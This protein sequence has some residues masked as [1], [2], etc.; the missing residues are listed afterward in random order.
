M[1]H[2]DPTPE[3][4]RLLREG[5]S[6]AFVDV[7][8]L[9]N[10][11]QLWA[12]ENPADVI[13]TGSNRQDAI[14]QMLQWAVAGEDLD[15]L[16]I[17]ARNAKPTNSVLRRAAEAFELAPRSTGLE[18]LLRA[19]PNVVDVDDFIRKLSQA[20]LAV[21]RVEIAGD[22]LGT[23]FLV[24]PDLVLTCYHVL[25][26]VLDG[27]IPP[28]EVAAR[29]DFKKSVVGGELQPGVSYHLANVWRVDTS[30][31][32][33]S[34]FVLMRLASK[35]GGEIVAG[36]NGAPQ[37]GWLQ[38]AEQAVNE[39]QSIYVIQHP[40]GGAMKI[41]L[42]TVVSIQAAA[43]KICHD[44]GTE[45]GSSGAPCFA[46]DGKVIGL[47]QHGLDHGSLACTANGAIRSAGI[48]GKAAVSAALV[49][50]D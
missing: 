8:S 10:L 50:G 44:A 39:T 40:Q 19:G 25:E 45:P 49:L 30:P 12:G 15:M 38:L 28:T 9:Q 4:W 41:S 33:E 5:F 1:A 31:K 27:G 23:G 47:H 48:L 29:F 16:L 46:M 21:C 24:G 43:G 2:I 35:A 22:A 11:I 7:A 34:D 36:Q 20:E 3:Q 37:R 32:T 18:S 17:R 13:S 14:R 42:G 26:S 6:A